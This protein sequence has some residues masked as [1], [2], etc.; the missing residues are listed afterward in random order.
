MEW[1]V[2]RE[3][4]RPLSLTPKLIRNG[5][6]QIPILR[7]AKTPENHIL[8]HSTQNYQ[9]LHQKRS[10]FA[11]SKPGFKP[12]YEIALLRRKA[13]EQALAAILEKRKELSPIRKPKQ[14][15]NRS[16]ESV[17]PS[18]RSLAFR[19]SVG[20]SKL[21]RLYGRT[22][23]REEQILNASIQV[24]NKRLSVLRSRT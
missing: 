11:P 8:S 15:A 12:L 10:L 5:C 1:R 24:L 22:S 14:E 3:G 4:I 6:D 21:P 23:S 9:L 20:G 19:T 2:R 17:Q 13:E 16:K 18:I 7:S